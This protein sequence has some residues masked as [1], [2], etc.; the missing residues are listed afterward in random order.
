MA[1]IKSLCVYCGSARGRDSTYEKAAID[2]GRLL[3]KR[4]IELVYGGG[5]LGLMGAVAEAALAEGGRVVGIIPEFL[6]Q[7]EVGNLDV[8]ELIVV[9][10]MHAR[11]ALMCDRAD[12]FCALPGGLGT[13]DETVELVTWS[14]LGLHQK[15]FALVD[16]GGFWQPFLKLLEHQV[17][18][19]FV[20]PEHAAL[21][22]LS[23]S[24]DKLLDVLSA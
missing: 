14:Q 4:D 22:R 16:C 7:R 8:S 20:R 10:S 17:K 6:L 3:A 5:R 24:V 2:L 15:P 1:A 23:P 21:I 13:L 11:K 12:A 19:G 18:E 9:P